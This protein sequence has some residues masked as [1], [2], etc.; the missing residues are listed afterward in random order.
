[1]LQI[2][3]CFY[4]SNYS[5]VETTVDLSE[6][7]PRKLVKLLEEKGE[8][9]LSSSE[10]RALKRGRNAIKRLEEEEAFEREM[11]ERRLAREARRKAREEA[12]K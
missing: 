1:M 7:D 8:G 12:N 3:L 9:N 6:K 10:A 11:E 4:R 5:F 2:L